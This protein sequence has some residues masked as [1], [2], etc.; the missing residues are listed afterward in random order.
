[1]PEGEL[2]QDDIDSLLGMA[3]GEP[4]GATAGADAGAVDVPAGAVA[5]V[6]PG[7]APAP[8]QA[9]GEVAP[10][11]VKGAFELIRDVPLRVKI[12]LGRSKMYIDDILKLSGGSVVELEKL[13]GDPLDILVNDR[14]VARGEL[15][16][17]DDYFCVRVTEIISTDKRSEIEA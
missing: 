10:E 1:M 3:G 17:L 6:E 14:L 5:S 13:A 16:V 15:I 2:S 8:V 7:L 9:G 12:E 11:Q 4:E